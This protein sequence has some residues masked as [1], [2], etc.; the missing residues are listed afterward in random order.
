[1]KFLI[2]L[3][4]L[5]VSCSHPFNGN[6]SA[7]TGTQEG[8]NLELNTP[9]RDWEPIFFEEINERVK[10]AKL[11]HLRSAVLPN[12]DLELRVWIGFGLIPLE[13]FVIKRSS[14]KWSAVHIRSIGPHLPRRDYQHALPS[15]K[16]GWETL[17]KR[18]N[19][20]EVETLPDSSQLKDG[21]LALDGESFVVEINMNGSYRTYMYANPHLQKWPEAKRMIRVAKIIL[22][23]FQINRRLLAESPVPS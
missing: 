2:I 14:G 22:E 1:M 16:S 4:L 5:F 19:D 3:V 13:G 18:L 12:D 10:I 9:N 8:K 23:E 11:N 21:V 15:P 7:T 6:N 20:E 17:W